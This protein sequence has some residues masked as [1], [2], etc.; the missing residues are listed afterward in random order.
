MV[1]SRRDSCFDV[2]F[3]PDTDADQHID[4]EQA[5][6][7]NQADSDTVNNQSEA[8]TDNPIETEDEHEAD[9]PNETAEEA[10]I[11]SDND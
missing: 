4:T 7:P 10:H 9:Y 3:D 2:D 1:E 11:Q 6:Y 8:E 5:D